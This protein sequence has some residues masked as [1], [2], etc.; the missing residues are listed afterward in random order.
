MHPTIKKIL[1]YLRNKYITA[2]VLFFVWI[3]FFDRNDLISEIKLVYKINKLKTERSYYQ[4]QTDAATQDLK[5][6]QTNPANLEKFA[7]EKYLMKKDNEDVYVIVDQ[8]SKLLDTLHV[9]VK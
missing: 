3:C 7:R 9:L 6:L 2:S 4:K 5:E 8:N 1:G